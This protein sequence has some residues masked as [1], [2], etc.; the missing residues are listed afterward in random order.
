VVD[1][2]PDLLRLLGLR[3]EGNGYRVST[4]ISAEEA[5]SY[6]S[7]Q[8]FGLL[9]TDLRMGGMDGLEL[10][11][12][13]KA[14][15]PILPVILLTAHGTIPDA[16]K[17]TRLGAF[18]FV[19]KPFD[20]QDLLEQVA[21]ALGRD[22]P[23][24]HAA[25]NADRPA[26]RREVITRSPIMEDLMEQT[27]LIAESDVSVLIHG[28]SGTGKEVLARA[29]HNASHRFEKPFLGVNCG[30]I[31][32][33]LLE[34]ELFGHRRGAFTGAIR[35]NKGLF[36]S[37]DT[38]TLLLDE[39]GDMPLPLQ[40][41]LLRVL[42][43]KEVSPVGAARPVA[44]DVRIVS[45]THQDLE[46]AINSGAFREDL[47]Y[48][49][50]VVSLTIPPLRERREDIP[51]LA[52]HFLKRI[53]GRSAKVVKVFAPESMDYLIHAPWPGNVRQLYNVVE[54][55]L[56]LTAGEVIP[57]ALVE[58]AVGAQRQDIPSFAEAKLGFER[59]YLVRL[60][61]I[62]NGNVAAAARMA[63]RNRTEFYRL[64]QRH[65]LTA[66]MFKR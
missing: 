21:K 48:R 41:K 25:D 18:G 28:E 17:A 6:L 45:A 7:A 49:L 63:K 34:S 31:A 39:I 11:S 36:Q 52:E 12:R 38:G 33:E 16:V 5:L 64:L 23:G 43:Q 2:D 1:D 59:D 55:T 19:T 47:Y 22:G 14:D 51:L 61:K 57:L 56:V 4:A 8:R 9:I 37:A 10:L 58:R 42:E 32:D 66:A 24:R 35:E 29:I 65:D 20:P 53:A 62:N 13:V 26:W 60:L 54:Q 30:A 44:V 15:Y 50:N 40:V 27:R 3:L 46:V